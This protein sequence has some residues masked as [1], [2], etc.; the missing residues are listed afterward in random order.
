MFYSDLGFSAGSRASKLQFTIHLPYTH[1]APDWG[2]RHHKQLIFRIW[3]FGIIIFLNLALWFWRSNLFFSLQNSDSDCK[4]GSSCSDGF[5]D[6]KLD[7]NN[8]QPLESNNGQPLESNNGQPRESNTNQSHETNSSQSRGTNIS[9]SSNNI[10]TQD[11][12]SSQTQDS[13][14][15]GTKESLFN[16]SWKK[17]ITKLIRTSF[18]FAGICSW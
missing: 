5:C 16:G 6:E 3:Q 14:K 12:V 10:Q 2:V 13:E 11:P 4:Q 18:K 9:Q 17:Q 7:L 15:E 1:G 8:S